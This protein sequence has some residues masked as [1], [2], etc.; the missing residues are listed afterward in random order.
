MATRLQILRADQELTQAQLARKAG[1]DVGT[2]IRAEQGTSR[3]SPLSKARLARALGLP[4]DDL[5]A[6]EAAL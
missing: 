3:I 6:E 2:V 5:F 4:V 1:V